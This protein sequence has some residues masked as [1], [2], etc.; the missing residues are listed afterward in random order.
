VPANPVPG[1]D[2]EWRQ[3][4]SVEGRP[5]SGGSGRSR[6]RLR[7]EEGLLLEVIFPAGVGSPEHS[8]QHDSYIYLLSGHL[9]GTLN[10][11]PVELQPGQT[12]LHPAREQH[13]VVAVTDSHW[14]EFKSP[15]Q[16]VWA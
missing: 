9:T 4:T 2:P 14:L 5:L 12:L 10:G 11:E 7:G 16:I 3:L 8:H 6:L 15:P 1:S 13:S